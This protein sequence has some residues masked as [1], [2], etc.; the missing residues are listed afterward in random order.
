[1]PA[2]DPASEAAYFEQLRAAA[3]NY[4]A[5][6]R[7]LFHAARAAHAS[8]ISWKRIGEVLGVSRQAAWERF[9]RQRT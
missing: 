3:E 5:A 9:G 7:E 8:G 1:M 4:E 2:P 6:R